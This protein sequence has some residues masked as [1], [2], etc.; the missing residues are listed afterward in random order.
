[1]AQHGDHVD[2]LIERWAGVLD[3]EPPQALAITQRVLH[4]GRLIDRAIAS[5]VGRGGLTSRGD[6]EILAALH[7]A[8]GPCRPSELARIVGVTRAAITQRVEVLADAG[9][10]ERR[11]HPADRRSINVVITP[12][13][14]AVVSRIREESFALQTRIVCGIRQSDW[15][16]VVR[17]LRVIEANLA[18]DGRHDGEVD[19]RDCG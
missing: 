5:A 13:G 12:A 18:R 17:A 15:G 14:R 2:E 7:R 8:A 1:M 6:Y 10:V 4:I 19:A 3:E 11:S 9:L 16:A